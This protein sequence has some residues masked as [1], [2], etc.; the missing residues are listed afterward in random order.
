MVAFQLVALSRYHVVASV[1]LVGAI[2][3]FQPRSFD[4]MLDGAD[5]PGARVREACRIIRQIGYDPKLVI[6]HDE[7]ARSA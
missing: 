7:A 5:S 1:R 4:L 3:G 2:G 6:V